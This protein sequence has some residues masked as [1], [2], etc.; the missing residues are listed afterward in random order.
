MK[1]IDL[2]ILIPAFRHPSGVARIIHNLVPVPENVEVVIS[3]DS[4][5]D[6]VWDAIKS[7]LCENVRYVRN[8][9]PK[10]AVKN[11]NYLREYAKGRFMQIIHHDESPQMEGYINKIIDTINT[12][13]A[14]V[15]VLP[16]HIVEE[17]SSVP[18]PHVPYLLR[19]WLFLNFP[20]YIF[21]RNLIG[22][23]SC[24]VVRKSI[25]ASFNEDLSWLVDV[26]SYRRLF[27]NSPNW[28]FVKGPIMYSF[29]GEHQSITDTIYHNVDQI[30]RI[31][32]TKIRKTFPN[33]KIWMGFEDGGIFYVIESVLWNTLR[34]LQR[35]LYLFF[36]LRKAP[37]DHR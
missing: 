13:N 26:E 33:I 35:T 6:A 12:S 27:N 31:E 10:G 14:D 29:Q 21:R 24:M 16:I 5:D 15:I 7:N 28:S 18:R 11:W 17:K 9:P 37:H 3:D 36:L 20:D 4:P 2:S 30:E 25:S 22:P 19:R 32:K 1:N 8:N 34:I 23:M